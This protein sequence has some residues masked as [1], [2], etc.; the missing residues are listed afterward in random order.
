MTT[1]KPFAD[2]ELL[3]FSGEHLFYEFRMFREVSNAIPCHEGPVKNALIESFAI[4]LRNL[5]D[6]FYPPEDGQIRSDDVFAGD[7]FDLPEIRYLDTIPSSLR[8]ARERANKEISHITCKRKAG[9]DAAKAW[10]VSD[11]FK[12]IQEISNKFAAKASSKKLHT[13]V[14]K[15]LKDGPEIMAVLVT[16]ASSSV[17][18][19]IALGGPSSGNAP[20]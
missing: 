12:E 19:P 8:G 6:F 13:N 16:N 9:A 18:N 1:R 11:L 14:T 5:I 15:L 4:H 17:S 7:F 10:S 20:K 2:Q 3:D